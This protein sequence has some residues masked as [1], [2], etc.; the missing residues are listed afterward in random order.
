MK[1]QMKVIIKNIIKSCP[2][3]N[4]KSKRLIINVLLQK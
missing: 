3:I 4:N 2:K 1:I